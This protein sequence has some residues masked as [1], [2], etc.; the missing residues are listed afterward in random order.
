MKVSKWNGSKKEVILM[1]LLGNILTW[2]W[3]NMNWLFDV[4]T[5]ISSACWEIHSK[6]VHIGV[7]A[8]TIHD[9]LLDH[10]FDVVDGLHTKLDR[11]DILIKI[12]DSTKNLGLSSVRSLGKL[13]LELGDLAFNDGASASGSVRS[14]PEDMALVLKELLS[15]E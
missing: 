6:L 8:V 5:D 14:E 9:L 2:I 4:E 3:N 10:H 15:L 13:I 7:R 12:R 11:G 1:V